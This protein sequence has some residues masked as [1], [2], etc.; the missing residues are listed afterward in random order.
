MEWSL[1]LALT[2]LSG[3]LSSLVVIILERGIHLQESNT[4]HYVLRHLQR[5]L[6][7]A[8]QSLV[9]LQCKIT[10]TVDNALT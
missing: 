4:V 2:E 10:R 3:S 5:A 1:A 7:T 6:R 9:K 8:Y